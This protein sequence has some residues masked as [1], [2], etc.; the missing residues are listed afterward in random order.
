VLVLDQGL[1]RGSL[2]AVRALT[3]DGWIVGVGLPFRGLSGSSCFAERW[4]RVPA[5]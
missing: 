3:D 5:A 1:D 2:A 4:H